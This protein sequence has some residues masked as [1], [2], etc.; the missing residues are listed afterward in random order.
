M[1]IEVFVDDNNFWYWHFRAKNGR[2]TAD[3][4][5]YASKANAI[6]AA[7]AVV[8]AVVKELNATPQ[9]DRTTYEPN[10]DCFE[11]TWR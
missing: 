1:K 6:R 4:E 11:I 9:F 3:A 7:K 10:T 2:I 5:A 8:K